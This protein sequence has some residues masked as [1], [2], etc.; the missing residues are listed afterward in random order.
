MEAKRKRTQKGWVS[1][2]VISLLIMGA[3]AIALIAW[4]THQAEGHA[5]RAGQIDLSS[6]R[7]GDTQMLFLDG[8][9]EIFPGQLIISADEPKKPE[10]T[11]VPNGGAAVLPGSCASYR[12]TFTGMRE[13]V[14]LMVTFP[15]LMCDY[16][17]FVDGERAEVYSVTPNY[18]Q[19]VVLR[20]GCSREL[21]LEIYSGGTSGLNICPVAMDVNELFRWILGVRSAHLTFLGI[22]L[23][24]F[25]VFPILYARGK[26]VAR[27]LKPYFVTGV[28]ALPF[29][30]GQTIWFYG[31]LDI[32]G[33]LI[34][35][36]AI[37][38]LDILLAVGIQLTMLWH[39]RTVQPEE[40]SRKESTAIGGAVIT[41]VT[42]ALA[43]RLWFCPTAGNP[44]LALSLLL[45]AGSLIST[46]VRCVCRRVPP[47][48]IYVVGDLA[49]LI[50]M[51]ISFLS[52]YRLVSSPEM[53]ILPVAIAMFLLCWNLTVARYRQ[54]EVVLLQNALEM[55]QRMLKTQGAFLASQIQPHFLYNTLTTIQE[56]C[57]SDPELAADT[58]L[59]FADY[60]RQ[61]IDFMDY[62][63]KVPF[64][65]ERRHIDNYIHIQR[66]RFEDAVDFVLDIGV[67]DF[68]LP[69]L[70][71]QPL[72][73]NAVSHGIRRGTGRGTVRVSTRREGNWVTVC[74][75]DD[76]AGFDS[77]QVESRSMENIRN[78]LAL[79]MHG[80]IT[81]RSNPG[82]GTEVILRI[83]YEEAVSHADCNCR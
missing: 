30:V 62:K 27:K 74:V 43:C 48:L 47:P 64:E 60:L 80:S 73:E 11:A 52:G 67:E 24:A 25:I 37:P 33:R 13:D 58:V 8:E 76:G 3:V 59:H 15:G 46:V 68:M 61:N 72:V 7:R 14:Q 66:A 63:N 2:V 57:W 65:Q 40:T 19:F 36:A 23:F 35:L 77:T 69:P 31:V 22:L 38:M 16:Q 21:V 1:A 26:I 17:I 70:T 32:V 20:G 50:G 53:L 12:L 6:Y 5:V 78:R 9:W 51:A 81:V 4:A 75:T 34:P 71:V 44:L 49:L 56:L 45:T 42:V 54:D 39:M 79:T 29:Y 83:P 41:V 55:E 82:E 28:L 18:L 10:L